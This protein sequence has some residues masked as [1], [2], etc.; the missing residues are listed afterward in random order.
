MFIAHLPA[1]YLLARACPRL[2]SGPLILGA[3]V[4]DIDLVLVYGWGTPMHHHDLLT[5][6]PMLWLVL[7]ATAAATGLT[8]LAALALGATVHVML[9]SWAGRIDW[10]WP[11]ASLPV[12]VVNVPA[13]FDWWVLNFL[14]HPSFLLELC[15]VAAALLLWGKGA[16][17]PFAQP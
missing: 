14:L 7:W 10:G 15:L 16:P 3:V 8:R 6:R 4:P 1:G 2:P 5:H 17:Q 12:T 9:D 13:R 11:V